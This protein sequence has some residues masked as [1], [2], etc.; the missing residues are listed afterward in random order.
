MSGGLINAVVVL[1]DAS[2]ISR[3]SRTTRFGQYHFDE[4]ATGE[5]YILSVNS[6]RYRF[7]T[8]VVSVTEELTELN[9]T[10]EP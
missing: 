6:K 5:T 2:S 3:T 10:P 8:R 9:F 4:V 7:A 1:T